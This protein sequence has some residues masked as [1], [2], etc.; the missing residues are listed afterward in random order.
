MPSS[1]RGTVASFYSYKGGVGRTMTVVNVAMTLSQNG[2]RVMVVDLDLLA[3]GVQQY[4]YFREAAETSTAA[5]QAS[6]SYVPPDQRDLGQG[7]FLDIVERQLWSFIPSEKERSPFRDSFRPSNG[8]KDDWRKWMRNVYTHPASHGSIDVIPAGPADHRAL[9]VLAQIGWFHFLTEFKGL[10]LVL[11][12]RD[13]WW[14]PEYDF[15]LIDSRTGLSDYLQ[16]CVGIL[17]DVS[18]LIAG[19]NEQNVE[20]FRLI[21]ESVEEVLASRDADL[22]IIPVLSLIPSGELEMVRERLRIAEQSLDRELESGERSI[23][24]ITREPVRLPYVATLAV[25]ERLVVPDDHHAPIF[26][27]YVRIAEML[28]RHKFA[29]IDSLLD[30]AIYES[31]AKGLKD[32]GVI[33]NLKLAREYSNSEN[34][35]YGQILCES[36]DA[37]RLA[38]AA[39]DETRSGSLVPFERA[40]DLIRERRRHLGQSKPW[41][42]ETDFGHWRIELETLVYYARILA[43]VAEDTNKLSDTDKAIKAFTDA[44]DFMTAFER[45]NYADIF[46]DRDWDRYSQELGFNRAFCDLTRL[47]MQIKA[48]ELGDVI[49]REALEKNLL[50]TTALFESLMPT[51]INPSIRERLDKCADDIKQLP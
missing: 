17:P 50:E 51:R 35:T 18:V 3:P 32:L 47:E 33:A 44:T 2:F 28:A 49:H 43:K 19:L 26:R 15:T 20:G 22:F 21:T 34:Y 40:I 1:K 24:L 30:E 6:T 41:V 10:E 23:R 48:N 14:R 7:G 37:Q 45:R 27:E 4:P 16:F 8:D 12:M 5:V 36:Y 13:E 29:A 42:T 38:F 46:S 31:A 11:R 9:G 25:A 39:T